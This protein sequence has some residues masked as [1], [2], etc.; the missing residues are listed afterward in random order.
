MSQP[1][2]VAG[3]LAAVAGEVAIA[4]AHNAGQI[5]TAYVARQF[6]RGETHMIILWAKP[7]W[8]DWTVFR[9]GILWMYHEDPKTSGPQQSALL[10]PWSL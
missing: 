9:R 5:Y 8:L 2:A 4:D 6:E 1:A 3:G 10:A 7:R